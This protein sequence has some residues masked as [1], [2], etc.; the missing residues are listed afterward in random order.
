MLEVEHIGLHQRICLKCD[1]CFEAIPDVE[2]ADV[3][4]ASDKP[5]GQPHV[6]HSR[7]C[8]GYAARL[9]NVPNAPL[10]RQNLKD[11]LLKLGLTW[12][13]LASAFDLV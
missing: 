8:Y 13:A 4:W 6:I 2:S 10:A 12:L 5:P 9:W 3:V 11:F 7:E 1:V